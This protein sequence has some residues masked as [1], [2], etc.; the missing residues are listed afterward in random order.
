MN[1]DV[2]HLRIAYKGI[3]VVHGVSFTVRQGAITVIIGANGAG[4]TSI[5]KGLMGIV[6]PTGGEARYGEIDLLKLPAHKKAAA[7]ISLCPEGRQLFPQMTVLENLEM[8]AYSR[9]DKQIRRDIERIFERF[10]RLAERRNQKAGTLSGGE[11]EMLAIARAMMPNPNLLI[12]DEPS[13]GLAPIMVDEVASIIRD[14]NRQGTTILLIEQN[15]N[16]ALRMADRAY[17]LD[18]G[19]IVMDGTGEELLKNKTVQEI[20]LGA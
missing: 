16:V 9:K 15:A 3:E 2:K 5:L 12:L 20:Y 14:I 11:Q 18:V 10:P 19:N 1:L 17:V 6:K 7:G 8:G 13:W 4:K